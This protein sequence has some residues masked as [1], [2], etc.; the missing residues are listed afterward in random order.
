ML[1]IIT[2]EYHH[3]YITSFVVMHMWYKLSHLTFESNCD[4]FVFVGKSMMLHSRYCCQSVWR[5]LSAFGELL[6]WENEKSKLFWVCAWKIAN[7]WSRS[8]GLLYFK[9]NKSMYQI[10]VSK[11]ITITKTN[12]CSWIKILRVFNVFRFYIMNL[13]NFLLNVNIPN[14]IFRNTVIRALTDNVFRFANIQW[15]WQRM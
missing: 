6:L 9:L 4:A 12:D 7:M 1:S 11:F 15:N 13:H 2:C 8:Y 3:C 10:V 14:T 5:W